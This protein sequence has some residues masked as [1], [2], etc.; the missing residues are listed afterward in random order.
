M[1]SMAVL[2]RRATLNASGRLGS[3]FSVSMALMVWRETKCYGDAIRPC[4][5]HKADLPPAGALAINISLD[6]ASSP[7]A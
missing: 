1:F 5:A 4:R 7:V 6:G 2:N 3:Y